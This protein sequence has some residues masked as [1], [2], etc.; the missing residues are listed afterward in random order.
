M[1]FSFHS[2]G[3]IVI[4]NKCVAIH[5]HEQLSCLLGSMCGKFELEHVGI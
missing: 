1:V 5:W 3:L 2:F 4:V